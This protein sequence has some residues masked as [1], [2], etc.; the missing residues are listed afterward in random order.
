MRKASFF[1]KHA[2]ALAISATFSVC[3]SA[4]PSISGDAKVDSLISQMT[5]DEKI[6]FLHGT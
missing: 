1:K 4:T 5:L 6:S 2:I 3:A